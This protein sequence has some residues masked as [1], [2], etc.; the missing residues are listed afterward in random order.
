MSFRARHTCDRVLGAFPDAFAQATALPADTLLP[1]LGVVGYSDTEGCH[2]RLRARDKM[3]NLC[4]SGG[5]LCPWTTAAATRHGVPA[6]T[7]M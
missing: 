5:A 4:D 1:L 3:G 2:L 7:Q 6:A